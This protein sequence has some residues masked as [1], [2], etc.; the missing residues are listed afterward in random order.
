MGLVA[1][2]LRDA[3]ALIGKLLR[4]RST[5]YW[6]TALGLLVALIVAQP[7]ID[8]YS[9]L[10]LSSE[11]N[12]LFQ[13]L[14]QSVTNP[15]DSSNVRLVIIRDDE[16]WDGALHHRVPT[17]RKYLAGILYALD[18]AEASVIALDFDLRLPHAGEPARLRDYA[19]V[20]PYA[21]YREETDELVKAID[22]VARRRKIILAKALDGPADGPFTLG[23][24]IYQ[25]Y[26]IC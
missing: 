7:Y 10:N 23:G 20:D 4:T 6:L 25:P 9:T 26:G 19:Q 22:D 8:T 11:R 24:D 17:D 5:G 16:Y 3:W 13:R 2:R 1:A 18:K 12:W 14:T 15:T 21:P